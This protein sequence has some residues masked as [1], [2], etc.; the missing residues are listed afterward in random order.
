MMKSA[1]ILMPMPM[2]WEVVLSESRKS[3]IY[4]FPRETFNRNII[5]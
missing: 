4:R 2:A 1:F 3:E 5:F